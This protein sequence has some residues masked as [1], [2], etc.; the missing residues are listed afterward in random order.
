MPAFLLL[1]PFDLQIKGLQPFDGLANGLVVGE[2]AAQPALVHKGHAH[3][4]R[5]LPHHLGGRPLGADKQ[6]L[7]AEG[8]QRANFRQ[9]PLK[10]GH[11]LLQVD[12]VY[13]VS[14]AENERRHL[15]VPVT[16]LMAEVYAGGQ[17]VTHV[18]VQLLSPG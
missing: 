7:L 17:Q 14:G 2:H 11:G 3:P 1:Q 9:R 8:R 18:D 16:G 12:D 15:R 5:L 10:G 13:L 4:G 6:D